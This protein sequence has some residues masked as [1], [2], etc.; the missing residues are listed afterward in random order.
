[1]SRR[2]NMAEPPTR[3]TYAVYARASVKESSTSGATGRVRRA[4]GTTA[5]IGIEAATRSQ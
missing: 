3:A 1:M 4:N 2:A 5:T